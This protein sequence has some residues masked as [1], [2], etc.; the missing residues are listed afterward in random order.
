MTVLFVNNNLVVRL[1][2]EIDHNNSAILRRQIDKEINS[3]PVKNLIF[4]ME[5]VNMM[6]SSGIGMILGRYKNIKALDGNVFIARPRLEIL[7][8]INISGL[9]KIIPVYKDINKAIDSGCEVRR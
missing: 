2:G 7:K 4:D 1:E 9:H 3:R 8:I 5:N 6:D